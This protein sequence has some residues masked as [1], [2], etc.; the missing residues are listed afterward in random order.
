MASAGPSTST[1]VGR[2]S[3]RTACRWWAAAG[4]P[5]LARKLTAQVRVSASD[6]LTIV[7]AASRPALEDTLDQAK[8]PGRKRGLA[9][10]TSVS[11]SDHK[12]VREMLPY[13]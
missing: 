3:S 10:A 5:A 1:A 11:A 9:R 8:A 6:V 7:R 12:R 2:A 4:D 13:A